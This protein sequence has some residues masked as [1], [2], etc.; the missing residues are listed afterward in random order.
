MQW[1]K[2]GCDGRKPQQIHAFTQLT[3]ELGL[4]LAALP[5][6]SEKELLA[7]CRE[8]AATL[9]VLGFYLQPAVD[10]RVLPFGF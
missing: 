3:D 5:H 10:G 4:S 6:A 9:P 8:I 1:R 7:H 2:T